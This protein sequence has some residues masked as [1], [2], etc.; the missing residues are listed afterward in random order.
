[1]I[2]FILA[3]MFT[4]HGYVVLGVLFYLITLIYIWIFADGFLWCFA[5]VLH[6]SKDSES[7]EEEAKEELVA[8]L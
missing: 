8:T 7:S 1:M 3:T 2:F 5:I 4:I 6:I